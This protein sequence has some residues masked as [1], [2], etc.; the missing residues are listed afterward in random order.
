MHTCSTSTS[1]PSLVQQVGWRDRLDLQHD[2][3]VY[4]VENFCSR[5]S[6]T[7]SREGERKAARQLGLE[8]RCRGEGAHQPSIYRGGGGQPLPLLQALG[9]RPRDKEWGVRTLPSSRNPISSLNDLNSLGSA[10]P[11]GA[12]CPWPNAARTLP[13]RPMP[14]PGRWGHVGPLPEGSRSFRYNT[15]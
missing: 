8:A 6:P 15:D 7:N 5:A 13:H 4:M 10:G 14:P 12:L 3:V 9:R 11:Y 1:P 2:G